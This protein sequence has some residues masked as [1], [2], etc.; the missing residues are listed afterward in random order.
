MQLWQLQSS[1]HGSG[2]SDTGASS[3]CWQQSQAAGALSTTTLEF[4]SHERQRIG[5]ANRLTIKSKVKSGEC[6][7]LILV[8]Q[9][10]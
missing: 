8:E 10:Q 7:L 3:L 1:P 9:W 5:H 2:V 4:V 6:M